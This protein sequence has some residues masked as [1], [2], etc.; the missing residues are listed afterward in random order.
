MGAEPVI[1]AAVL[2]EGILT[3][4]ADGRV[5]TCNQ[6]A[7]EILG[8]TIEHVLSGRGGQLE[9]PTDK[10][11]VALA[12]VDQP[13]ARAMRSGEP[14]T[15]TIL[16]LRRRGEQR[17]RWVQ[18]NVNPA[19]DAAGRVIGA[20][21][22]FL[23]VTERRTRERALAEAHSHFRAVF[24]GATIGMAVT[25]L[26]GGIVSVN[27][28]LSG[29]IGRGSEGLVGVPFH[30]L[31]HPAETRR[32]KLELDELLAGRT[33]AA[34]LELRLGHAR[35]DDVWTQLDAAVLRDADGVPV[36][37]LVQVQDVSE[38][39]RHQEHLEHLAD[40]DTLTGLLNR[41][42]LARELERQADRTRRYGAEGALLLID[43][44]NFKHVNDT[45]GH[46]AGDEVICE[47]A[48]RIVQRV[49]RSDVVARLGGDEF[50]VLMPRGG[51]EDAQLVASSLL[52]AL[53]TNEPMAAAG[54][55]RITASIGIAAFDGEVDAEEVL[56]QADLAMYDAKDS[57]R[58]GSQPY[59]EESGTQPRA[60]ERTHWLR[61]IRTAVD[62]GRL[63]L[64]AQPIVSASS[65]APVMHELLLRMAADDG[66]LV[67]PDAF[68]HTAERFDLVQEID[69]WVIA[70]ACAML[71]TARRQG[72]DL[73]LTVNLSGKSVGGDRV[74]TTIQDQLAASGA[75]P[76]DLVFEITETS[77]VTHIQRAIEFA[78]GAHE[79]GCR[80]AIDDFG[81]GFGS[82]HYLKHLPFDFLKIDGEF[83]TNGPTSRADELI[84]DAVRDLA[85]G[86]GREV[87]A[88]FCADAS[89]R[90]WLTARGI[91]LL[92]GYHVG[93]PAPV[94]RILAGATV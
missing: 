45:L 31:A 7:A 10:D 16:G 27:R 47:I 66:S 69:R 56:V 81:S 68:L 30:D 40:H 64:L 13:L 75:N 8:C 71:G 55:L 70:Q 19:K 25:D 87:I 38:R 41:R 93:R 88:E 37:G 52:H 1:D 46:K 14:V 36:L 42:G 53:R 72:C 77:A 89:L 59:I 94:E 86:L 61:R 34:R 63:R 48:E 6:Q 29:I 23:D 11:G 58:D 92:Q 82:F 90:D 18:C 12:D 22:A 78:S 62:H 15:G 67:T 85:H 32:L 4:D 35:G 60:H 65:G 33:N 84:V 57:G 20:T 2:L 17:R 91:D 26:R 50:A 39:R 5:L 83:V 80:L 73:A 79:L 51:V 3:F 74:L 43:L 24:A 54:G 28:A 9:P 49:R 76:N 21:A 44:D